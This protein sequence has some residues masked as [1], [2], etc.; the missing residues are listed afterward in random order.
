MTEEY[1]FSEQE[2]KEKTSGKFLYA[3]TNFSIFNQDESYW[4]EYVGND[5]YI[6]RSDN[7]LNK[8]IVITPRQMDC[9]FS[10]KPRTAFEKHLAKWFYGI[11][12]WGLNSE[13][14]DNFCDNYAHKAANELLAYVKED[15]IKTQKTKGCGIEFPHFGGNYPDARCIDGYLWDLDSYDDNGNYTVGGDDPC[16]VCNT[17]EWLERVMED[18]LFSTEEKALEYVEKLKKKYL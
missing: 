18:E 2:K 5:T 12:T 16:P 8:K 3:I 13:T 7:I 10:E 6:G 15:E 17:E 14:N 1:L 9:Y 4:L 11:R